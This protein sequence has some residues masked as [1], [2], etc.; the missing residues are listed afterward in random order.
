MKPRITRILLF[1]PLLS[2]TTLAGCE[3]LLMPTSPDSTPT[4]V[5]D[6]LWQQF[7]RQYSLFDVKGVDWQL[8]Y[9]T[10]RPKVNESISSD[11]LFAIC[12]AMLNTLCDGH[13]NLYSSYDLSHSDSIIHRSYAERQY[14]I[15]AIVLGYLGSGYHTTGGVAHQALHHGQVIYM[16]YGSFSNSIG[17]NQLRH[18]LRT[19]PDARG[20]IL[21]IRGNG[22]GSTDNIHSFLSILP[23]RGQLLYTS[24][25]KSGP[26]HDDFTTPYA[27]YAP[28]VSDTQAF[29]RPVVV[30]TDRG[31]YSASSM[32]S[33]CCRAYPN[34][35]LLG[36]TT[37]GGLAMPAMGFLSNG[38]RYRLPVTRLLSPQGIN[39]ENG[40]PPH[41]VVTFD[42]QAALDRQVDNLID[43]ACNIILEY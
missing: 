9:D 3:K 32:F 15:N 18:I 25:I 12:A 43:S 6:Q 34:V 35:T 1:F 29:T 22:G 2:L 40:V 4:A 7:D 23:S 39:Y 16:R 26:A 20:L 5:F 14:D 31:C 19:Y 8:V 10:L 33:L 21:D 24:Q 27:T 37:G 36:D 17:V 41:R 28:Q 42:R 30:L 11:S 38:W 13:V